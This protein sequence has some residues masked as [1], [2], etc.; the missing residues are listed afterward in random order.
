MRR[1][2]RTPMTELTADMRAVIQAAHLCFAATVTPD[3]KPN[4]SPKGTIRVWDDRHL[5]FLDLASPGTRANLQAGPWMEL[6]VVEQ[7]SRRGYRFFGTA[8]V[9]VADAV[10]D[11][12]VRRVRTAEQF[13]YPVAAVI[14]LAVVRAAPLVSP[15]YW[16]VPDE[17]AMR[18]LWRE[19]R[20]ALDQEF[21]A[22]LARV[23]PFRATPQP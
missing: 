16:R 15:G 11:E 3:G 13:G 14:L 23:E 22:Y 21:E 10:Y 9:H 12:A 1:L 5:F 17:R 4:L 2:G 19:R 7:L 20:E 6:N 18:S 8:T